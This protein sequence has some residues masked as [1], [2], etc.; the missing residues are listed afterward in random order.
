MIHRYL[1]DQAKITIPELAWSINFHTGTSNTGT[2]YTEAGGVP[3]TYDFEW[4]YPE[5]MIFIRSSDWDKAEQFAQQIHRLFHKRL[6][7]RV[8]EQ[9]RTFYVQ[10]LFALSEPIRLGVSD[11]K[12]EYSINIRA[13]LREEY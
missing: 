7:F 11:D 8:T 2:V 10:S 4:R 3:D 12:M 9:G 13:T 1:K 5:Y 6:D